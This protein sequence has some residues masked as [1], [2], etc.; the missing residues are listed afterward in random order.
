MRALSV[1]L[2]PIALSAVFSG[3]FVGVK[4]IVRS[5]ATQVAGQIFKIAL[6]VFLVL[7]MAEGGVAMATLALCIS[8]T[9]TELFSFAFAFFQYITAPKSKLQGEAASR[10]SDV[11]NMALPLAFSAYIRSALL[12]LEHVLIP[13]RLELYGESE[14]SALSSYGTLHGMAL[15]VALYPM[16]PL[17]SFA[18]LLVPEFAESEAQRDSLRLKRICEEV[19]ST[20]LRYAAPVAVFIYLFSEEI[21][22]SV[23]SSYEAGH[24]IAM[25]A[26]V[27]PIM[28]LD[29]VTDAMLKGIGEQVY[30]MWVNIT[31]SLLSVFLIW[32]L[33]PKMGISGYA[34]VIIIMEAYN[35]ALSFVRLK[36]RVKFS[37][38]SLLSFI[39][40]FLEASLSAY[41]SDKL[42]AFSGSLTTPIQLAA[43]VVFSVCIFIALNFT[44]RLILK[45]KAHPCNKKVLSH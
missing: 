24:Y 42:F 2:I 1:S 23:Y 22:Y 16:S 29:H 13:R 12:T 8:T 27:I 33:L 36:A 6:T 40:P 5:S 25:L 14:G 19:I 32:L 35:F 31:D 3:Y 7:K 15:P 43:K 34:W 20:T 26:P 4:K 45:K 30:S 18:S 37:I 39:L 41:L 28:Y 38:K 17:S 9:L 21:A 11:S 44:E 10:F